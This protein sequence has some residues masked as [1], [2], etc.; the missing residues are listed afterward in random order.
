MISPQLAPLGFV[1]LDLNTGDMLMRFSE[2]FNSSSFDPT[3]LRIQSSY[4]SEGDAEQFSAIDIACARVTSNLSSPSDRLSIRLCAEDLDHIRIDPLV[5]RVRSGCYLTFTSS[6]VQDMSGN[7]V[8]PLVPGFPGARVANLTL[9]VTRPRLVNFSLD[10]NQATLQMTFSKAIRTASLRPSGITLQSLRLDG[11]AGHSIVNYTLTGGSTASRDGTV[12]VMDL[13]SADVFAIKSADLAKSRESTFLSLTNATFRDTAFIPNAVVSILPESA[14]QAGAYIADTTAPLLAAF[15]LVISSPIS[16]ILTF[17]EPMRVPSLNT[18]GVQ[19]QTGAVASVPTLVLTGGDVS[20]SIVVLPNGFTAGRNVITILLNQ[21]DITR[22]ET[23]V[24]LGNNVTDTWLSLSSYAIQ[25]MASNPVVE[26]PASNA[27]QVSQLTTSVTVTSLVQADINMELATLT[28]SFSYVIVPQS[29]KIRAVGLQST[30][31]G[32]QSTQSYN[33][34]SSTTNSSHGYTLVIDL[35]R[36]DMLAISKLAPLGR[37]LASTFVTLQAGVL[38]DIFGS[39]V[40]SVS[41]A[42]AMPVSSHVGRTFVPHLQYWS[43]NMSTGAL[44]MSFSDAMDPATLQVDKLVLANNSAGGNGMSAFVSS[45]ALT[46][47]E[48]LWSTDQRVLQIIMTAADLNA[49]KRT[50]SIAKAA[51]SSMMA[52]L[53]GFVSSTFG[54]P[55]AVVPLSSTQQT[56]L[57]FPDII[58]PTLVNF[59]FNFSDGYLQLL[60]SEVVRS[61]TLIPNAYVLHDISLNRTAFLEVNGSSNLFNSLFA[62]TVILPISLNFMKSIEMCITHASCK[63][64]L[65]GAAIQ[66]MNGNLNEVIQ[67]VNCFSVITDLQPPYVVSFDLNLSSLQLLLHFDEPVRADG[68]NVS[69]LTLHE[70]SSLAG[71]VEVVRLT[72]G[73]NS[74]A[75]FDAA[76]WPSTVPT[77][78]SVNSGAGC[79][80]TSGWFSSVLI[81]LSWDDFVALASSQRLTRAANQTFLSVQAGFAADLVGNAARDV[82]GQQVRMLQL[83]SV[84]PRLVSFG[85]DWNA[86]TLVLC[87]SKVVRG[88]SLQASLITLQSSVVNSSSQNS[89]TT[90]VTFTLSGAQHVTAED[91]M[92]IN[93]TLLNSDRF[94]I[95]I[96]RAIGTS[97]WTSYLSIAQDAVRDIGGNS[98]VAIPVHE[99]LLASFYVRDV[100]QPRLLSARLDMSASTLMLNF[101]KVVSVFSLQV[102]GIAIQNAV[103]YSGSNSSSRVVQLSSSSV[104][105]SNANDTTLT[106]VLSVADTNNISARSLWAHL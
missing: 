106:I 82:S 17:N 22:L 39:D 1:W 75:L 73:S 6:L 47:G 94:A 41:D 52:L 96:L 20:P 9:D 45:Y 87:F 40:L 76:E 80:P 33:L 31:Q 62:N 13:A 100:V 66:D 14:L 15:Q 79:T 64:S 30:R 88:T 86:Q 43:V 56:D 4:D 12:V 93:V 71:S 59:S 11:S 67:L 65:P 98:L 44:S 2:T 26:V 37:S 83:D 72:G 53:P 25:D 23:S 95:D 70:R 34:A 60:F 78:C 3:A 16:L 57:F 48:Q 35:S 68:V 97:Q 27:L 85:V 104:A 102:A 8:V 19:L 91:S 54:N 28:L 63:L 5:C 99:A 7:A 36:A 61:N 42:K 69:M 81:R 90:A 24:G 55:I 49:V 38:G 18:T 50:D 21:G 89:T 101:S 46:G 10:M 105:A 51:T 58:P 103:V 29:L 77:P 92:C 84:A 74:S 32:Q